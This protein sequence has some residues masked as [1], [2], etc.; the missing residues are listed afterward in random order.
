MKVNVQWKGDFSSYEGD[1]AMERTRL[2]KV[3]VEEFKSS[4]LQL[5][6]LFTLVA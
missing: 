4:H 1:G 2:L 6:P 3:E 5:R